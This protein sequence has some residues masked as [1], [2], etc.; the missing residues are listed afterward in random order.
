MPIE[1]QAN[2]LTTRVE[3]ILYYAK[4]FLTSEHR[5]GWIGGNA[6]EFF[7]DQSE[8]IHEGNQKYAFY[9]S[10]NHPFRPESMIS[11]FIPENR[12]SYLEN[13]IYPDCSIK[14]IEHPVSAESIQGSFTHKD[15]IRHSISHGERSKDE[16]SM[17]QPFLIK[18]GGNPRLIQDEDYY[19]A[20]LKKESLSFFF[21]VDE[22]GYP[23]T[24]IQEGGNYPFGFG[25]LYIFAKMGTEIEH[26]V[27]GFCQFS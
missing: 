12:E 14:V 7:D 20:K 10:L 6:P 22:D 27:A 17:E 24:L 15:L 21:Q 9:L 19:F 11:I 25:S 3:S 16:E 18:A 4:P 23:D 1:N 13:N 2:M 5:A 26:P 8:L